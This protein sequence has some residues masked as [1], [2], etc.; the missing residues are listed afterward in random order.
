MIAFRHGKENPPTG[1][2]RDDFGTSPLGEPDLG[3]KNYLTPRAGEIPTIPETAN[4]LEPDEARSCCG[5]R[6]Y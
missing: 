4:L 3:V 1:D 6:I 2:F 5:S